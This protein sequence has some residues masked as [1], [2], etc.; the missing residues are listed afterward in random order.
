MNEY[1]PPSHVR[2]PLTVAGRGLLP[3]AIP[4]GESKCPAIAPRTGI[5]FDTAVPGACGVL[6]GKVRPR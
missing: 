5:P 6:G 1:R 2:N 3:G 4:R